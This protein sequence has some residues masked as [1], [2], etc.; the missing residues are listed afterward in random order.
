MVEAIIIG[1]GIGGLSAAAYLAKAGRKVLVLEQES[2]PGGSA[3]V[4]KR[5]G[6]TFPTGPHSVTVPGYITDSLSRLGVKEPPGFI[7]D[8]F[9][10]R[11]GDMDI[12]ISVPL[13]TLAKKLMNHFPEEHEGIIAIINV[14]DEVIAALDALAPLDLIEKGINANSAR[15]I[16]GR[17]GNISALSLLDRHLKDQRLKDLLGN[18]G[19]SDTEM[20]VVLLA[21]MWRFMSKEGIWYIQGGIGKIPEHLA[22]RVR[23]FGGEIR[24]G[25]RVERILVHDSAVAGVELASGESIKSLVVI[26]D[27]DYKKTLLG[28]LPGNTI[29]LNKKEEIS[30]MPLTSSAFTVFVGV[31]KDLVDLSAF[32]GHHLLVKLMEG[33]PVPWKLK[34]PLLD[35]FMMDDIWLSWWSKHDAN[36]APPGYEALTIKVTAPFDHFAPYSGGGRGRHRDSYYLMKE[37]MAD[38]LV[39]AAS[40]VIP[41]LSDA[42]VVRE[43]ASPLT[44][45]YWGHRSEGSVAGWSW[46]SGDYPEP[47]AHSLA[48]TPVRGLLIVGLQSF[49]RLFYVGMGTAFYRGKYA[50]DIVLHEKSIS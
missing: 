25:E 15:E 29:M 13:Q 28:L 1:A 32:N 45:K 2:H 3:R 47:W 21:N 49:T 14:L 17:W 9:E 33:E 16:I 18:Q 19:T 42:V 11:R 22:E 7:R 41:G 23:A 40:E 10:V 44:Y 5:K 43:V 46:R 8:H 24:F 39:S 37:E 48:I 50:A 38:A 20:P 31:K 36:L 26:S 34:K 35:D 6:F 4:F 27:A 12:M 30:R